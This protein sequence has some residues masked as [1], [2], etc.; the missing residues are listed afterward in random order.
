MAFMAFF[1]RPKEKEAG[2]EKI[3][4][5]IA[6]GKL[7]YL[8]RKR[9]NKKK[10][11]E[12][13]WIL[14]VFLKSYFKISKELT[15]TELINRIGGKR[16]DNKLKERIISL[17]NFFLEAKYKGRQYTTRDLRGIAKEAKSL[18]RDM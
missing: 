16:I 7:N 11:D 15:Y 4:N 3:L 12:L 9:F 10:V 8:G 13:Y 5:K 17:L 1:F 14:K 6:I 18:I 2:E